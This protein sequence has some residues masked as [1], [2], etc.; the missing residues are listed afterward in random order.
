[1]GV[2]IVDPYSPSLA[3][4]LKTAG[5]AREVAQ[6]RR[7]RAGFHAEFDGDREGS[8]RV[9]CIVPA[10]HLQVQPVHVPT[11]GNRNVTRTAVV[12]PDI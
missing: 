1:M 7:G 5:C 8:C 4:E 6:C 11:D 12:K 9:Q 3:L 10:G 2:V